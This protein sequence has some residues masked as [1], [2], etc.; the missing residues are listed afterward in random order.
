MTSYNK[1]NATVHKIKLFTNSTMKNT[2]TKS[3]NVCT[4]V[5]VSYVSK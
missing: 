5:F 3:Q 4:Q 2:Y 1:Q